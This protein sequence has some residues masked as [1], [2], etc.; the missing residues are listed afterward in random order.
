MNA[1]KYN[2]FNK[3]HFYKNVVWQGN[4]GEII[5]HAVNINTNV[6]MKYYLYF[7]LCQWRYI[8]EQRTQHDELIK[9]RVMMPVG[10]IL[11]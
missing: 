9:D 6:N 2:C 11:M 5:E 8:N 1:F 7:W 4:L 3:N 10:F